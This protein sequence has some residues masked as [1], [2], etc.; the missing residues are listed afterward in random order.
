[1]KLVNKMDHQRSIDLALVAGD[2]QL[3]FLSGKDRGRVRVRLSISMTLIATTML[4]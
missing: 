1:M 4:S 2:R 3:P